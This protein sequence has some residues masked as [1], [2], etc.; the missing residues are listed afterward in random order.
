MCAIF[1]LHYFFVAGHW[2]TEDFV[3]KR[4]IIGTLPVKGS[5][6]AGNYC[7]LSTKCFCDF[8]IPDGK[9]QCL[10]RDGASVMSSLARMLGLN[11]IHCFAHQ[12]QLVSGLSSTYIRL[13]R[14]LMI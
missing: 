14:L 6:N 8:D 5:P 7:E 2:L 12:L 11:S 3:P 10:V 4:A 1:I 9:I 13:F